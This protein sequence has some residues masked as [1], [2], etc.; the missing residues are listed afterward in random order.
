MFVYEKVQVIMRL[1]KGEDMKSRM[2][3]HLAMLAVIALTPGCNSKPSAS[4]KPAQQGSVNAVQIAVQNVAEELT[5]L[6]GKTE[7]FDR[8]LA[9]VT[10]RLTA[11]T[12]DGS[13][14]EKLVQFEERLRKAS[15]AELDGI[16][17]E[18][19][20]FRESLKT[21]EAIELTEKLAAIDWSIAVQR[22]LTTSM[23]SD[24]LLELE[25]LM[26]Q[27]P[28]VYA[29]TTADNYSQ[30]IGKEIVQFAN[31]VLSRE[32][33]DADELEVAL[34]LLE[35]LETEN[36]ATSESTSEIKNA[37]TTRLE[38]AM[39]NDSH[40]EFLRQLDSIREQ[41]AA[42]QKISDTDLRLAAFMGLNQVIE[43]VRLQ[44]IFDGF[45]EKSADLADLKKQVAASLE[46][47]GKDQRAKFAKA[48]MRY[49]SWTLKE[50]AKM[51][52]FLDGKKVDEEIVRLSTSAK[53]SGPFF[54][55]WADFSGVKQLLQSGIGQLADDKQLSPEQKKKI[56][57]F[58]NDN[59][60]KLI[61]QVRHD[62]AVRHIL[63]IDQ[64]LLEPPV[65]K[66]YNEAFEKV[67][68]DLKDRSD[69]QMSMAQKTAEIQ[70]R[71]VDAFM[72]SGNE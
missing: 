67:W 25:T 47:L 60:D 41:L 9:A 22:R 19:E 72:E 26:Q 49:Q 33:P 54:V 69:L 59:T 17:K 10:E 27:V 56:G 35:P 5:A 4:E 43:T 38:L 31:A 44:R 30:Q 71:S 2:R 52:D 36:R 62:A 57:P 61:A 45:D 37:L 39:K 42:S 48:R 66:F 1:K 16:V 34:D 12:G 13:S 29:G 70:K 7:T 51:R 20:S 32:P 15:M 3:T 6:S 14:G 50:I 40:S 46:S 53:E 64:N 65:A 11:M 8:K 58:V 23:T 24:Q 18:Y 63:H 21:L 55:P 68:A 28:R